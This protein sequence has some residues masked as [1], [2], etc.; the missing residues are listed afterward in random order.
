MKI[1]C[2]LIPVIVGI[3]TAILGYLMGRMA[4]NSPGEK[5]IKDIGLEL[6]ACKARSINLEKENQ[7]LN[8]ELSA[9]KLK[10]ASA[11]IAAKRTKTT[12][13]ISERGLDKKMKPDNLKIIKGIGPK[14]EKLLRQNGISDWEELSKANFEK[15]TAI[16]E[17]Q[18]ASYLLH[19]HNSWPA[20]AKLAL[21]GKWEEL[22]EMW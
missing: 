19:G 16:L 11:G 1:A 22:K 4:R 3:I 14:I 13:K 6:S 8:G 17:P 21:E 7:L 20:Q 15:L 9:L 10:L 2:I 5:K 18:G 12:S